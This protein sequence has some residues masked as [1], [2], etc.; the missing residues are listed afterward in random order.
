MNN[1]S[2]VENNKKWSKLYNDLVIEKR[3]ITDLERK[4]KDSQFT[5]T[6]A[7]IMII[8]RLTR[9]ISQKFRKNGLLQRMQNVPKLKTLAGCLQSSPQCPS[10][11]GWVAHQ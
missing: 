1:N 10:G 6:V 9:A 7:G 4:T 5:R 8:K 2:M 3:E 11:A